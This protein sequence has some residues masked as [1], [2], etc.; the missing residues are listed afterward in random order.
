M[1]FA[2]CFLGSVRGYDEFYN[3]K[4]SVFPQNGKTYSKTIEIKGEILLYLFFLDY[5]KNFTIFS[6]ERVK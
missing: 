4:I 3:E 2:N 1:A 5:F 6:S